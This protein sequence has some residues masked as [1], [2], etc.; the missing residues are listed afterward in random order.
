MPRSLL[1]TCLLAA[2]AI[3]AWTPCFAQDRGL[4]ADSA[5][6]IR[7][8]RIGD[9]VPQDARLVSLRRDTL[10]YR[11]G[12][13]CITDTAALSSLAEIDVSRG[14][15]IDPGRVLGGMTWGLLAGLGAGWLVTEIGCRLPE[16]SELCGIGAAKW[17]PIFGGVG[18][19]SGAWWGIESREERWERIY[20]P[21]WASLFVSPAPNHGVAVG[22]AMSLELR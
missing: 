4:G 14:E 2:L 9:R 19:I 11:L 8:L 5:A 16:S 17:M 22:V 1:A 13:C 10:I 20:P 15:D 7:V 12:G 6:R 18:L 21:A 3:A